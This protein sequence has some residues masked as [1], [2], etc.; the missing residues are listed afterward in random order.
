[1]FDMNGFGDGPGGPMISGKWINKRTGE[2]VIIRDSIIDGDKLILISNKGNLS[3]DTFSRDYIQAS[4]EVYDDS[5]KV[6]KTEAPKVSEIVDK[7]EKIDLSNSPQSTVD[8]DT[9]TGEINILKSPISVNNN[10]SKSINNFELI[11]K[12]FKKIESKPK[13]DLKITW[14]GFPEKELSM[15]VNYFDVKLEDIAQYIGKYLINDNLLN[16]ALLDFLGQKG[17]K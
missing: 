9:E 17:L 10:E 5:G 16:V 12:I 8:I 14:A 7:P 3:F 6:I 4:D 13:A 11:D 2:T 15:L 1:M